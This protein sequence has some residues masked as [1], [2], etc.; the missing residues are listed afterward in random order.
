LKAVLAELEYHHRI[1][2][3]AVIVVPHRPGVASLRRAI[4]EHTPELAATRSHLERAF[5]HFLKDRGFALPTFNHPVGLSTVD[6]IYVEQ[7]IAIELDGVQGHGGERRILR[8]HRRDLH[9]R[10]EGYT[11]LRYHY[12]QIRNPRDGD[13]I[14]AELLRLGVPCAA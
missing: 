3:A 13:L 8:D 1:D 6:A 12:Q 9:R 10:R 4:A 14:A 2:P 11:P 5:V 7:R